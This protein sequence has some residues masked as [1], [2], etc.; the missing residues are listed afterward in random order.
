[1]ANG[2]YRLQA[3]GILIVAWISNNNRCNILNLIYLYIKHKIL[4]S[5]RTTQRILF[6][7]NQIRV[8]SSF[9]NYKHNK[10]FGISMSQNLDAVIA[11]NS[12]GAGASI[13]D[14]VIRWKSFI[15]QPYGEL[16]ILKFF[17]VHIKHYLV[18]FTEYQISWAN[19]LTIFDFP[20]P[21]PGGGA[22]TE[23]YAKWDW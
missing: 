13:T 5:S 8:F 7:P 21:C 2:N 11:D 6:C 16:N 15:T 23:G 4:H 18:A 14:Q 19:L 20:D 9:P 3:N 22:E 10:R 1:M 17:I 12:N